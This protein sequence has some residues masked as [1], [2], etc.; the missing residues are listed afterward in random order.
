MLAGIESKVLPSLISRDADNYRSRH[1]LMAKYV[2]AGFRRIRGTATPLGR[3]E[4]YHDE[5]I[6]GNET[7]QPVA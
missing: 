4:L 5:L 6:S 7:E 3:G 1:G 2:D